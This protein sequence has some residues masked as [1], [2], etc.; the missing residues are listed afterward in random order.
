MMA[1][2]G[3]IL[4]VFVT[5]AV[6]SFLFWS[7]MVSLAQ[8]KAWREFAKR[9][10]LTLDEGEKSRDPMFMTGNLNGRLLNIYSE[11]EKDDEER[12]QRIYTHVEVFFYKV[13]P[14]LFVISKKAL[15]KAFQDVGAEQVFNIKSPDWTNPAYSVTDD[16]S[17]LTTWL[18]PL[19][20]KA[21]RSFFDMA[22]QKGIE[23]MLMGDGET[24]FLL[25]R[26]NE[27]LADA[28]AV[29]ALVQKLYAFARDFDAEDIGTIAKPKASSEMAPVDSPA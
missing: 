13:P 18:T 24:A 29:N 3:F 7:V 27:P 20:L 9:Y 2:I 22:E 19:R 25:W 12:T 10:K 11:I 16:V 14:T 6:L 5:G 15:P 28:R 23:T 4:W 1:Q 17:L 8:K 21:L 26:A